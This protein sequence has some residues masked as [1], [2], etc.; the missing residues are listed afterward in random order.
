MEQIKHFKGE[1]IEQVWHQFETVV[2]QEGDLFSLKAIFEVSGTEVHLLID[3]DLGG[4]FQSGIST[5]SFT[6]KIPGM[7]DFRFAL[8][9]Q[10]FID[11][12]GK[13][14]GMEDIVIGYEEFDDQHII[15]TN[16]ADKC[17]NVFSHA[18][19]R[20]AIQSLDNFSFYT[21]VLEEENATGL[22]LIINEG[23]TEL[24][25]LRK[26]YKAFSDVM[27]KLNSHA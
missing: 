7:L 1:T 8:H 17:K 25:E 22:F 13:F 18:T 26:L 27:T 6:G 4:G 15:K 3:I 19:T 12:I 9:H 20:K 16:S 10:R 14:F 5:T 11:E 2:K 23:I 24:K 21:E